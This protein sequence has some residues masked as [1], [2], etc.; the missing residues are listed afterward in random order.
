MHTII[1]ST[2][3]ATADQA[4]V[5]QAPKARSDS[6]EVQPKRNLRT[7]ILHVIFRNTRVFGNFVVAVPELLPDCDEEEVENGVLKPKFSV[8]KA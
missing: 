3:A 2:V 7:R 5:L 4:S 8:Q 6:A 1:P